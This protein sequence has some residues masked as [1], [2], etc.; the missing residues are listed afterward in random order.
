MRFGN[1]VLIA[2]FATSVWWAWSNRTVRHPP[3][4]LVPEE[5]TQTTLTEAQPGFTKAG[6]KITPLARF[7]IGGAGFHLLS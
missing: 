6:Y 7:D 3:G 1:G 5:P 2:L 4:V